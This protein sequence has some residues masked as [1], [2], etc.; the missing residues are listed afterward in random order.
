MISLRQSGVPK[1]KDEIVNASV[2]LPGKQPKISS[3]FLKRER[4][5]E[6]SETELTASVL[7]DQ[8]TQKVKQNALTR[9]SRARILD[10]R[11]HLNRQN[12]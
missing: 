1:S 3:L 12:R 7:K 5:R 9:Q 10:G 11:I 6:K 8:N 4:Q 2:E